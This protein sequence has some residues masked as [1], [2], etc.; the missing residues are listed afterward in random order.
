MKLAKHYALHVLVKE[1]QGIFQLINVHSPD[2]I[3]W[4][5]TMLLI[6][7]SVFFPLKHG[8]SYSKELNEMP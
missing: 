3:L 4:N 5:M 7:N 2:S 1:Y 6:V 8:F